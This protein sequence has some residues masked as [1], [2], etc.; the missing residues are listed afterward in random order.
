QTRV[1]LRHSQCRVDRQVVLADEMLNDGLTVADRLY[2]VDDVG[3][4]PAR[5]RRSIEN[6]LMPKRHSNKPHEGEHLQAIA[7]V[8]GHGKQFGIGKERNHATSAEGW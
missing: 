4:L 5:S 7:V 8:I 3:Q 6:M 2:V 1:A